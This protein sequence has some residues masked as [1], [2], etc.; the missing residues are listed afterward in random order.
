M[1][2]CICLYVHIYMVLRQLQHE[3]DYRKYVRNLLNKFGV[4][5]L[6]VYSMV[7][8]VYVIIITSYI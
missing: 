2:I 4:P 8:I 5:A 1:Y 7:I 6:Y 3:G